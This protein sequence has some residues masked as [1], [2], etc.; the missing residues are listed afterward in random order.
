MLYPFPFIDSILFPV[1]TFCGGVCGLVS[2]IFCGVL[3]SDEGVEHGRTESVL[4]VKQL[5]S[6][7]SLFTS[8]AM[9]GIFF[10]HK[11]NTFSSVEYE[12]RPFGDTINTQ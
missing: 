2:S 8:L 6:S 1:I 7:L 3:L 9:E 11:R 10:M 12:S 5:L 4:G